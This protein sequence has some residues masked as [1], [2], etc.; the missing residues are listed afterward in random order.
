METLVKNV[1]KT[2]DA[3]KLLLAALKELTMIYIC[4]TFCSRNM[5]L[6][7]VMTRGV[8]LNSSSKKEP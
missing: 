6:S 4:I 5:Y 3:N 1:I 7:K 8:I 2:A